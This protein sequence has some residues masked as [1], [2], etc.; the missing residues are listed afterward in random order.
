MELE[1][2][3]LVVPFREF[4]PNKNNRQVPGHN[5]DDFSVLNEF[6]DSGFPDP[7]NFE[8]WEAEEPEIFTEKPIN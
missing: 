1:K 2:Q 3:V 6:D 7:N 8:N 4:K 5:E